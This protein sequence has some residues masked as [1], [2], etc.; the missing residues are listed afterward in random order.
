M[1]AKRKR[2]KIPSSAQSAYTNESFNTP[3]PPLR[4]GCQGLDFGGE[5]AQKVSPTL[6]RKRKGCEILGQTG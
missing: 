4:R 1:K 6:N 3:T 5:V 2:R